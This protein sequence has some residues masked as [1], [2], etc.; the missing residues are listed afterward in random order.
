M[1]GRRSG[2]TIE[3]RREVLHRAAKKKNLYRENKRKTRD[4]AQKPKPP[5]VVKRVKAVKKE[6]SRPTPKKKWVLSGNKRKTLLSIYHD[7]GSAGAFGSVQN[8]IRQF[9]KIKPEVPISANEVRLFLTHQTPHSLHGP[10][11]IN[12]KTNL[13]Y[14]PR[15]GYHWQADLAD[16]SNIGEHNENHNFIL[17]IV[18]ILSKFMYTEP[19]LTKSAH[20]VRN[21]FL[22]IFKRCGDKPRVIDSD[23]GLEFNNRKVQTLFAKHKIRHFNTYGDKKSAIAERGVRTLKNLLYRQFE[24]RL[25]RTWLKI[26]KPTTETY[27]AN[28]HRSIRMSPNEA[29][30]PENAVRLSEQVYEKLVNTKRV[31]STLKKG[32]FVRLN[33]KL[34]PFVKSYEAEWS[35]ELLKI[36]KGPFYPNGGRLP[37]YKVEY[38]WHDDKVKGSFYEKE[39]KF[40]D[41]DIYVKNYV[42]PIANILKRGPKHSEVRWLGY[43]AVDNS[44]VRNS[45]VKDIAIADKSF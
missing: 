1:V 17:V 39:L 33:L 11:R 36:W 13:I 24:F 9:R 21:A 32:D 15:V 26:L 40:V 27:N 45:K 29:I 2:K 19:L 8:I 7:I 14:A 12:Y 43:D 4:T 38:A 16:V 30:L 34:G 37:M 25:A 42:F 3:I 20:N 44:W 23:A 28:L 22:H 31:K 18:D 35:R 5:G 6:P 41:P 10:S